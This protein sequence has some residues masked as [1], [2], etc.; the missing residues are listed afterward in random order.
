MLKLL[1]SFFTINILISG[2]IL[3]TDYE[4]R[5]PLDEDKDGDPELLIV[6]GGTTTS[7]EIPASVF[8]ATVVAFVQ[9][10]IGAAMA[11]IFKGKK[12]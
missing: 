4:I 6:Y 5:G 12:S 2:K 8:M 10:T 11:M 9:Q 1:S 3:G 7:V